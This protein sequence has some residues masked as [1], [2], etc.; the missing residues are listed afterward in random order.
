ME[1]GMKKYK[2]IAKVDSKDFVRYN[3]NDL[4]KFTSFLDTQ[5]PKWRWFNV[6]RYTK[7]G[8]GEQLQSFT[9]KNRP[10]H[11]FLI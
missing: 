1:K 10:S 9:S 2:V 3:V 8:N 4:L 7:D 6:Y 5:F 11:K